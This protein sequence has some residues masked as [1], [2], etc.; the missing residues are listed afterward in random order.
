MVLFA[1][2]T[3]LLLPLVGAWFPLFAA[4]FVLYNK[5]DE[6]FGLEARIAQAFPEQTPQYDD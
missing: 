3:L 6:A 4:L 2:W 1:P 5:L